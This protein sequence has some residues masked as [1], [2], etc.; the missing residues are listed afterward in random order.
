MAPTLP[1]ERS[2]EMGAPFPP[3]SD[4]PAIEVGEAG[5]I[6]KGDGVKVIIY[7]DKVF[8]L[9]AC[10][11]TDITLAVT[12]ETMLDAIAEYNTRTGS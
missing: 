4:K 10:D 6:E 2:K 12:I 7:E 11:G 9:A 1:G 5:D 3:E 8:F